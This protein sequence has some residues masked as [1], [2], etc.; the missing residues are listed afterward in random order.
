MNPYQV[1]GVS[2]D[3]DEQEVKKAYRA[4]AKK[5]HPDLNPED[6]QAEQKFK[7][8]ADAYEILSNPQKRQNWEKTEKSP[9]ASKSKNNESSG[10]S[11]NFEEFFG[12][13]PDAEGK[14]KLK[15]NQ[16]NKNPIDVS[17]MFEH[18]MGFK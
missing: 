14:T 3:A 6:V 17:A 10:F 12:F 13:Y 1:L 2:E 5:Y 4:L 16:E 11:R 9:K 7:E 8:I 18:Y 15:T